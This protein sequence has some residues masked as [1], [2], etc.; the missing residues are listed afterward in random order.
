[1]GNKQ[2]QKYELCEIRY[3]P[4]F[5]LKFPW[6]EII[7]WGSYDLNT[8]IDK[9]VI[10]NIISDIKDITIDETSYLNAT[11]GKT[12][13]PFNF[14][15]CYVEWAVELLKQVHNLKTIRYKLV[16]KIINEN[17]FWK[18]YFAT[19]K[20]IIVKNVFESLNSSNS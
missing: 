18:R 11:D 14:E 5:E 8:N 4:D 1:M 3:E 2:P 12:I 13:E 17:E 6:D 20:I 15:N 7:K 9:T 10:Q 19:I 16:P